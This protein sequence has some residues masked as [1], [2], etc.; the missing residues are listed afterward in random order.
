M[1]RDGSAGR[2]FGWPSLD[3]AWATVAVL[4]PVTVTFFSRTLAIDLA[5][6]MRAGELMLSSHRLLE[7]DP[8]TFTR[9]GE[10]WLNEQWGAQVLLGALY[11]A[12]GW[13]LIDLSRGLLV[14]VI[15]ALLYLACRARGVGARTASLLTIAGW[16]VGIE[17]INQLRPQLFAFVL[18]ALCV[19]ALA[20]RHG[21]PWRIWIVPASV[22][23]WVDIHGSFPLTVVLLCFA[24]LEDRGTDRGLARRSLLAAAASIAL[25]FVNPYG[26]RVWTYVWDLSTHPIVSRQVAEW[27]P[28][29]IHTWTGRFFFASLL[30]IAVWLARRGRPTGWV[31]L[32]ELGTFAVLSLLAIRGVAWWGLY[33]PVV[34]A[35][36]IADGKPARAVA[37]SSEDL[38]DRSPI[39]A[40]IIAAL[41][42]VACVGFASLTG[43]DPNTGAPAM[44]TLAPEQLIEAVRANVPPGTHVFASEL[45]ASW[46]EFSAPE[47]PLAVDPR[48]EIFPQEIWDDYF[49][50]STGREGWQDVL[51]RWN[52]DALILHPDQDSG[53]LA[54]I[55]RDPT[56]RLVA[57]SDDGSVYVRTAQ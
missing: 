38:P 48:I 44:L 3:A 55:G 32:I 23:P 15:V 14:G 19:W 22:V 57:D 49:V 56:W 27:G 5:Y 25:T 4:V 30:A 52:V 24:W 21:H 40:V 45:Q 16:L 11:R 9:F 6:Q 29:S 2:S 1:S 47:F 42:L 17:I 51:N 10:P 31:P 34:V 20:T 7:T 39:N 33:A 53:L 28:P 26:P 12:G 46:T 37:P 41:A 54:V 35:G 50:V 43:T 8:F 18:F 36:L 13:P